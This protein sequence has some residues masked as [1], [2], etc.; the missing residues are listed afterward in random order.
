QSDSLAEKIFQETLYALM[1]NDYI[2]NKSAD[3]SRE[4]SHPVRVAVLDSGVAGEKNPFSTTFVKMISNGVSMNDVRALP[5][6][7]EKGHGTGVIMLS[8]GGNLL[9]QVNPLIRAIEVAPYR[10]VDLKGEGAREE[11]DPSRFAD[12]MGYVSRPRNH[13]AVVNLSL[14]FV[15]DV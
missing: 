9:A 10:V 1:V 12:G 11:V 14:R 2:D 8:I 15:Q 5:G 13:I 3:W 6:S 7:D 4:N